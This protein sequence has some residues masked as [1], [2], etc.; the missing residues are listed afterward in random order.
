MRRF[1]SRMLSTIVPI[2]AVYLVTV[3]Y[4]HATSSSMELCKHE[5]A[6]CTSA[7]CV[8][9][10]GDPTKAVCSCDVQKGPSMGTAPCS[11]LKPSVDAG[12]VR[13]IYSTFSFVQF[14]QGKRG[15]KC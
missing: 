7:K 15:M 4:D 2:V 5:Y 9:Q 8:P 3:G 12:G 13:T 11:T 1:Y 6:L 10:P 14:Q